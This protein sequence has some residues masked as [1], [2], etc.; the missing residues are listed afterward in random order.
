MR[1][2][3]RLMSPEGRNRTP[4]HVG[5]TV[6]ACPDD[7][8]LCPATAAKPTSEENHART[9]FGT[10]PVGTEADPPDTADP[11]LTYRAPEGG[12]HPL[13]GSWIALLGFRRQPTHA[14]NTELT[15]NCV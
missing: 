10:A 7:R 11:P 14:C 2:L 12:L 8:A 15:S 5:V 9:R 6:A 3:R 4:L 1:D 13:S